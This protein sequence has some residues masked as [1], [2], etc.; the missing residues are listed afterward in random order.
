MSVSVESLERLSGFKENTPQRELHKDDA[1]WE[2][3]LNYACSIQ[4]DNRR[5]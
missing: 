2:R 1:R 4:P 5:L 3:G